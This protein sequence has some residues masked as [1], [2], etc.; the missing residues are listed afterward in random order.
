MLNIRLESLCCFFHFS[1]VMYISVSDEKVS[2]VLF[3][4]INTLKEKIEQIKLE[5]RN[6]P[7]FWC[8]CFHLKIHLTTSQYIECEMN[9]ILNFFAGRKFNKEM[10]N[11]LLSFMMLILFYLSQANTQKLSYF[12]NFVNFCYTTTF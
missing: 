3:T 2:S 12:L 8:V 5:P 1:A 7:T 10:K 9:E 6:F 11:F 4:V